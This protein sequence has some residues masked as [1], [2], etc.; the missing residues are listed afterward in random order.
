MIEKRKLDIKNKAVRISDIR[1]LATLFH[2]ISIGYIEANYRE[3]PENKRLYSINFSVKT[4]GQAEYSSSSLDIFKAGGLLDTK[5]PIELTMTFRDYKKDADISIELADSQLS[6]RR[7]TVIVE[8]SDSTWVNG[9]FSRF[10]DCIDSW[11]NQRT[12]VKKYKWLISIPLTW[13]LAWTVFAIVF[14]L[15]NFFSHRIVL[16]VF[17]PYMLWLLGLGSFSFFIADYIEK[18]WPSIEIVPVP[19]HEQKLQKK[20]RRIWSLL[21]AIVLPFVITLIAGLLIK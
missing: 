21:Y 18:L 17:S 15:I 16:S 7:S 5:R 6:Y 12:S 11:E 14:N 10:S 19:E 8:G 2:D 1:H 3:I 4:S 9:I 20:R 13:L